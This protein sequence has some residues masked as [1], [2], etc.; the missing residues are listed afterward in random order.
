MPGTTAYILMKQTNYITFDYHG[1]TC[2]INCKIEIY[3]VAR[4][5]QTGDFHQ[6]CVKFTPNR[7]PV[8]NYFEPNSVDFFL[9]TS[10]VL[11]YSTR[12]GSL[13]LL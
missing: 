10:R 3:P 1:L 8:E 12:R 6:P 4:S 5:V 2:F 11:C 7:P 13:Q 9:D